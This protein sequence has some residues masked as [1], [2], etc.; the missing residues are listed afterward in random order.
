MAAY[1]IVD[2]HIT[3]P[4]RYEEYK[5]RA[6]PTVQA[7]GGRYIVRGGAVDVLEGR[8]KPGR[9]VVLEF[10]TAEQARA[11]WDSPDYRPARDLRGECAS[12]EMILVQ[13]V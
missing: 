8:S 13:G 9:V 1:V 12:T 11:W 10:P 5:R 4:L 2:I 7:H 3:D 6:G